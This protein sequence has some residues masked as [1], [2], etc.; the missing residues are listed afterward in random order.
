MVVAPIFTAD[1]PVDPS[2]RTLGFYRY[3]AMFLIWRCISLLPNEIFLCLHCTKE[4][5]ELVQHY[6]HHILHN[7]WPMYEPH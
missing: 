2:K 7:L 4:I 6:A 3:K 1:I 5:H